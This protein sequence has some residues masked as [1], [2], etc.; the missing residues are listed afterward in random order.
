[1]GKRVMSQQV[2]K[3]ANTKITNKSRKRKFK[4]KIEGNRNKFS[5]STFKKVFKSKH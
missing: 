3:T 4:R 5:Q 1:M 2:I